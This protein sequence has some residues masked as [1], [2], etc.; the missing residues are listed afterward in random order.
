MALLHLGC[1]MATCNLITSSRRLLEHSGKALRC[2]DDQDAER[3]YERSSMEGI[4][5][6]FILKHRYQR[7]AKRIPEPEFQRFNL[8]ALRLPPETAGTIRGGQAKAANC[9]GRPNAALNSVTDGW[10]VST[11]LSRNDWLTETR[12]L[13]VR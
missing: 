12:P 1:R 11:P 6:A 7:L 3:N 2:P 10:E 5:F 8:T 9:L 4:V 13:P